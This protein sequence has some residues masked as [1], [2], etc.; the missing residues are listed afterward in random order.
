MSVSVTAGR[1]LVDDGRVGDREDGPIG[2]WGSM[3][4]ALR[5]A[6]SASWLLRCGRIS[7][8]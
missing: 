1:G 3:P 6:A 4:S 5:D 7:L 2:A 8:S